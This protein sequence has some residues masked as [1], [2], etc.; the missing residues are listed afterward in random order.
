MS[1]SHNYN[2]T[3]GDCGKVKHKMKD[4]WDRVERT[5]QCKDG[6]ILTEE[7]EICGDCFKKKRKSKTYN[8]IKIKR[9]KI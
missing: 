2:F 8:E 3:C 6:F 1:F 4:S 5:L 7:I 9:V